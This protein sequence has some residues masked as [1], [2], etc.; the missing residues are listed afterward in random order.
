MLLPLL[1]GDQRRLV[2]FFAVVSARLCWF[3]WMLQRVLQPAYTR[4]ISI[5]KDLKWN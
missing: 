5:E 3:V 4:E 2:L 1:I